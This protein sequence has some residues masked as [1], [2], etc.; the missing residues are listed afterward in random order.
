MDGLSANGLRLTTVRV[1]RCASR[2]GP[3]A[4]DIGPC[5]TRAVLLIAGLL[6]VLLLSPGCRSAS[7]WVRRDQPAESLAAAASVPERKAEPTAEKLTSSSP[8]VAASPQTPSESL[9]SNSAKSSRW[10]WTPWRK[11]SATTTAPPQTDVESD[12]QS[13]VSVVEAPADATARGVIP[14]VVA[15][16]SPTGPSTNRLSAGGPVPLGAASPPLDARGQT[17]RQVSAEDTERAAGVAA[18][19]PVVPRP[20][21]ATPSTSTSPKADSTQ[22]LFG[23]S[24]LDPIPAFP[25]TRSI[26]NSDPAAGLTQIIYRAHGPDGALFLPAAGTDPSRNKKPESHR[27]D[28]V[29]KSGAGSSGNG[30][31]LPGGVPAGRCWSEAELTLFAPGT[32]PSGG[33]GVQSTDQALVILRLEPIGC[34]TRCSRKSWEELRQER[35]KLRDSRTKRWR[36]LGNRDLIDDEHIVARFEIST[37]EY[38]LVAQR[39]AQL[40]AVPEKADSFGPA[41]LAGFKGGRWIDRRVDYDP[42]LDELIRR[43]MANAQS[44]A[45]AE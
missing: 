43:A 4:L 39:V 31:P 13:K 23:P 2:S 38:D 8:A 34:G 6:G 29:T 5:Q 14:T 16:V 3:V 40:L 19:N 45:S 36:S 10:S 9:A 17:I 21:S 28:S 42:L 37:A 18:G 24:A 41:E 44:I 7:S 11:S 35:L 15:G 1:S 12:P 22:A 27:G 33:S 25:R 30:G 26:V 20:A 32:A